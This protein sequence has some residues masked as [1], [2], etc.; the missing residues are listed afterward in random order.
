LPRSEVGRRCHRSTGILLSGG[1]RHDRKLSCLE[2]WHPLAGARRSVLHHR[3]P[4]RCRLGEPSIGALQHG[5]T[6]AVA[7]GKTIDVVQAL[8]NGNKHV[9]SNANNHVGMT[10]RATPQGQLATDADELSARGNHSEALALL[11][12]ALEFNR[13]DKAVLVYYGRELAA[14]G[15]YDEAEHSLRSAL[16]VDETFSLAWNELGMLMQLK[17]AFDKGAF[18]KA[19]FCYEQSARIAPSVEILT[20]LANVQL[21]FAP[22]K[23]ADNAERALAIDSEWTEAQVIRNS[24]RIQIQRLDEKS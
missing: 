6:V 1:N 14:L 13:M 4:E 17:G 2:P 12:R 8:E 21:V 19:A 5:N 10:W 9:N 16:S 11:E 24:A 22:Q 7:V 3:A 18:E 15:R 23:A 20:V